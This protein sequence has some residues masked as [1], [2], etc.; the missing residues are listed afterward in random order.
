MIE[1]G[2]QFKIH[3]TFPIVVFLFAFV[4]FINTLGHDFAWDD[5]IVIQ[6]NERVQKGIAGIPDLFLKYNSEEL[7]D[8]YGYRP[9]TL[10][11]LAIEY[12][13]FGD[14]P[15][16]FHFMNILYFAL[17]CLILFKVLR[18]LF[19]SY[20]PLLP[21]LITM[22]FAAH[23]LH[24]EVVANI[25]S[26][27]EL[28]AL[29][30]CLLSLYYFLEFHAHR[31]W[32]HLVIASLLFLAGFL[33][34]E[35]AFTFLAVYPLAIIFEGGFEWRKLLKT[36]AILPFL[37]GFALYI[38]YFALKSDFGVDKTAGLGVYEESY[39]LGNPFYNTEEFGIK[40][41]N[42]F[43]LVVLNVKNF[44][45]PYPLTYQSDALPVLEFH[46]KTTLGFL[47]TLS[48]LI[49][50]ILK[51][52]KHPIIAFGI[53]FF[54]ITISVY[55]QLFRSLADA[56]ADRFM[57]I[58]SLGL[59][60]A[61]VGALGYFFKISFKNEEEEQKEKEP[62]SVGNYL[63][64]LPLKMKAIIL[65][66]LIS[67]SAMTFSRNTVWKND[68]TL[69]SNDMSQLDKAARPHYY[70]ASLLHKQIIDEG[71]NEELESE[72]IAHYKKSIALSDAIYYGRLELGTYYCNQ[73]RLTEG[74][75]V[76]KETTE[77]FP[78][79]ADPRHYLGQ[80]YFQIEDYKNAVIQL[81]KSV[82]LAP[83]NFDSQ[84]LLSMS[85]AKV[86]RFNDAIKLAQDGLARF[87][88]SAV[89]FYE[90]LS[91]IYFEKNEMEQSTRY[92]MEMIAHGGNAYD[93]YATII[94]RYQSK[95]NTEK[96]AY[97]YQK[98]V[99]LGIMQQQNQ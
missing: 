38:L 43:H 31:K 19:R 46:W 21:F 70:Y 7:Q 57:F 73:K 42:S 88:N 9:V 95:N 15:H 96:A 64:T 84:H 29:L 59:C 40:V 45:L 83:N 99:D 52:K 25:K 4:Q 8:K 10:T 48:S 32:Q 16:A 47:L 82:A 37:G 67:L 61:V 68:F 93:G 87:S 24:V 11:T 34:K 72:M 44:F 12:S 54:F 66:A 26:R 76:L 6:E 22:L 78:E 69:I 27:D 49:F 17:L 89:S 74:I 90:A 65:I 62:R 80:A 36:S 50:A 53:L 77:I 91:F 23:P 81:E 18:R 58:P 20:N 33:S 75:A 71:W 13:F 30:F 85:Y 1:K 41:A 51:F 94:G 97:Y 28:L 92:T 2:A 3:K 55:L 98:A 56:M 5:K 35:N 60:I 39:I 14:N 79:T 86:G 63:G